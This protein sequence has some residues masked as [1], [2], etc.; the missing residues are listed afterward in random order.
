M[1]DEFFESKVNE[2]HKIRE[3]QIDPY[4]SRFQKE[5][6]IC[7]IRDQFEENKPVKT[8][9]RITAA[10][11]MGKTQFWDLSDH[12]GR[13][14]LFLNAKN[15]SDTDAQL[16]SLLGVGDFI[17]VS[18]ELFTTK[19]G[20]MSVRVMHI[21]PLS[22]AVRSLP[23][24][25]HGLKDVESR[26][27]YRYLDLIS[28]KDVRTVFMNRT[29]ILKTIRRYL[30]DQHFM[31]VE[32]PM[33][34]AHSGGAA[35]KP[36]K[37]FHNALSLDLSLR[38]APE[39]YLKR[40]LVGGLERVYELNRNFRN[41]GLSRNHNPEFTML[42]IYQAYA[43]WS[44]MMQLCE[45]LI[46]SCAK[47]L[48]LS[49]LGLDTQGTEFDLVQPFRQI[50]LF[51]S[52]R[53][54]GGIDLK[55]WDDIRRIAKEQHIEHADTEDTGILLNELFERHVEHKLIEP[56]FITEYP[57]SLCPLAKR[58]ATDPSLTDRF[59]LYISGKE[60]ANAYSELNDPF[61]QRERFIQ[62]LKSDNESGEKHIDEDFVRALEHGMPPAGGLGI[63]IDRLVMVLTHTHSIREVILFPLLR[64]E[65]AESS[66]HHDTV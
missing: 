31:E 27:R 62:Q 26:F 40:L 64:P 59:E 20:E 55:N 33:L 7:D 16:L 56:T 1:S 34:H 53:E 54:I 14:Q 3:L 52:V 43:D 4:G 63:G 11:N 50:S 10:R 60:I 42:E 2:L 65:Q 9:G 22:K 38:I 37:T 48:G 47:A 8:A 6:F 15:L 21:T 17:G 13:I 30:D 29:L 41:E 45:N 19:T 36:F 18:G 49:K 25:Y 44:D 5:G 39:L 57:A 61:D 51:D 35:A 23:E 46:K 66:P 32:T 28:N 24:K 58:K 12:T